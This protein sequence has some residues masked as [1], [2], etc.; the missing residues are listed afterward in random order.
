MTFEVNKDLL[1][2]SEIHNTV[3]DCLNEEKDNLPE[4]SIDEWN[5]IYL[6]IY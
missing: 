1:Q 6:E 2:G 5:E 4:L 3:N